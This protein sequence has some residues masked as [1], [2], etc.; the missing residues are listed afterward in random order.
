MYGRELGWI[1]PGIDLSAFPHVM[2]VADDLWSGDFDRQFEA[3]LDL[4]IKGLQGP[5]GTNL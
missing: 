4:L 1:E 5:V 3:G 2:A